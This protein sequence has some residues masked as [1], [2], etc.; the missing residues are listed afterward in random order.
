MEEVSSIEEKD[1]GSISQTQQLPSNPSPVRKS[2]R[3]R[4]R[5]DITDSSSGSSSEHE[6]KKVV[7][8]QTGDT[9]ATVTEPHPETIEE[10]NK[11]ESSLKNEESSH[12]DKPDEPDTVGKED[13][14]LSKSGD[15]SDKDSGDETSEDESDDPDKLYCICREP[16][17]DR[18]VSVRCE[19]E[20]CVCVW[21]GGPLPTSKEFSKC[22]WGTPLVPR[23]WYQHQRV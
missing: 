4:A 22:K 17:D 20:V 21:G 18:Y 8:L 11:V 14:S 7:K 12:T 6:T 19:C 23:L 2:A 3:L 5:F 10:E 16:H 1:E 9:T 13:V 15:G